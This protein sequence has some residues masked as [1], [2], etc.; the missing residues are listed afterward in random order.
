MQERLFSCAEDIKVTSNLYLPI[1]D[2]PKYF[3]YKIYDCF[4]PMNLKQTRNYIEFLTA[5]NENEPNSYGCT[6]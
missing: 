6:V 3:K 1:E 4:K 5:Q 2:Y